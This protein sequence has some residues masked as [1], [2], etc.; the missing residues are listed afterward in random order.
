MQQGQS[1]DPRLSARCDYLLD[2]SQR[3]KTQDNRC[4]ENPM[5]CVQI[6]RRDVG[7]DASYATGQCWRNLDNEEII[8]DDD[9]GFQ[10]PQGA[11]WKRYGYV[12]RWETVMATFTEKGCEEYL[13]LNGHNDRMRAHNGEVRIC[14][15]SFNRCPEMIAIRNALM[16]EEIFP[17]QLVTPMKTSIRLDKVRVQFGNFLFSE[18]ELN[19]LSTAV[20]ESIGLPYHDNSHPDCLFEWPASGQNTF[21][22][23]PTAIAEN[24]QRGWVSAKK[25]Y[26]E[27][28]FKWI[29]QEIRK[30]ADTIEGAHSIAVSVLQSRQGQNIYGDFICISVRFYESSH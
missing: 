8:Y 26:F 25:E 17:Q 11:E 9:P 13:A 21:P 28:Q 3:L 2:I 5:F 10:E 24:G 15:E 29:L 12:D 1:K 4:T 6:K 23:D 14:I 7:Y 18:D 30:I 19:L 27:S 22:Q 20:V 16:E